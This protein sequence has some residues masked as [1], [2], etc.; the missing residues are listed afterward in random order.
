MSEIMRITFNKK[1]GFLA[2][3]LM[4]LFLTINYIDV[5]LDYKKFH[6]ASPFF[7]A[8]FSIIMF[9]FILNIG[10]WFSSLYNE[11]KE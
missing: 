2:I 6:E 1:P 5:I 10:L 9:G 7:I 3:I 4:F 8:L 11:I